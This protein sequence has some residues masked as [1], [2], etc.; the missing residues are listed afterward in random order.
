ML[1]DVDLTMLA[2]RATSLFGMCLVSDL[3]IHIL[4]FTEYGLLGL[5]G[6]VSECV[7]GFWA[8]GIRV[9]FV[10]KGG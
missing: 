2:I 7:E 6:R 10:R 3:K 4:S 1:A 5:L 8:H 9:V